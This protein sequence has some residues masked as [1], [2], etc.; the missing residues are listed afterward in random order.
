[1]SRVIDINAAV[2]GKKLRQI[3]KDLGLSAKEVQKFLCLGSV[4]SIYWW[5][6]G[7]RMIPTWA[8]LNLMSF[9]GIEVDELL[10]EDTP[11][12]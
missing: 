9:Y 3:R 10:K 5:E 4:V 11:N 12:A 2:I 1:M 6:E 8:L 7:R